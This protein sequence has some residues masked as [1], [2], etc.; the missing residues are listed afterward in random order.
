MEVIRTQQEPK[1]IVY[2]SW[3]PFSLLCSK[4][5]N[6]QGKGNMTLQKESWIWNLKTRFAT[7]SYV[8]L[9]PQI[10]TLSFWTS[11]SYSPPKENTSIFLIS[12]NVGGLYV[13]TCENAWDR[14]YIEHSK[15]SIKV[16]RW[17]ET[18][19]KKKNNHSS[20]LFVN[21][22][23]CW[24]NL[25]YALEK[26]K[27]FI[28]FWDRQIFSLPRITRVSEWRKKAQKWESQYHSRN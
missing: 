27:S 9:S 1:E 11:I 10:A 6:R 26:Q 18:N 4:T 5:Q 28:F 8:P 19:E 15:H 14:Q 17:I 20:Y 7:S 16:N 2:W 22:F 12:F 13:M 3:K 24:V 25:H 21:T 23:L